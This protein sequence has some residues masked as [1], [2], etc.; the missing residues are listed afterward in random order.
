[1]KKLAVLVVVALLLTGCLG[2]GS[3]DREVLGNL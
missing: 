3:S 1:M 2:S